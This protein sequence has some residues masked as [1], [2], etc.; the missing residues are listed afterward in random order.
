LRTRSI[1][2]SDGHLLPGDRGRERSGLLRL[3]LFR[4][5]RRVELALYR[6]LVPHGGCD[7][8]GRLVPLGHS[9]PIGVGR[10]DHGITL[11]LSL[12]DDRREAVGFIDPCGYRPR[13]LPEWRNGRRRGL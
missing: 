13:S 5:D 11:G 8:D 6:L 12:S 7:P 9:L 4:V 2:T 1:L 3:G 10:P